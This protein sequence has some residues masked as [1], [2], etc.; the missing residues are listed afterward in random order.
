[1]VTPTSVGFCVNRPW[2][3]TC[4]HTGHGKH[5]HRYRASKRE[6]KKNPKMFPIRKEAGILQTK[7]VK[8]E[9]RS[10]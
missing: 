9:K 5:L 1:M 2:T 7:S 8:S 4:S 6:K 3:D 10:D